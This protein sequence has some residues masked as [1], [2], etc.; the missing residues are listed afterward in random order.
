[1]C[2]CGGGPQW[3]IWP[4]HE[5]KLKIRKIYEHIVNNIN[6]SVLK[7]EKRYLHENEVEYCQELIGNQFRGIKPQF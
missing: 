6:L 2:G 3:T 1:M 4:G 5:D 7:L